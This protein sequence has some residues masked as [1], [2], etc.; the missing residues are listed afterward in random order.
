MEHVTAVQFSAETASL[1]GEGPPQKH[2]SNPEPKITDMARQLHGY[3][4]ED[5]PTNVSVPGN[6]PG[7]VMW[8]FGRH[9][10]IVLF[11]L[12]TWFL[13]Q[14]N[15]TNQAQIYKD[16]RETASQ[17]MEVAKSQ[18]QV[19]AQVVTQMTEL[20]TAISQMVDEARKVHQRMNP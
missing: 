11:V 8:A 15:K 10:P 6:W 5:T 1:P 20:K 19:N 9:G 2:K 14:D 4:Q 17:M 13:Y 3:A 18:I 12:S 7:I 16:S